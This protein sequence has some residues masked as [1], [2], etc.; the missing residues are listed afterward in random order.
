MERTRAREKTAGWNEWE[1]AT[2]WIW[3]DDKK[4]K[5]KLSPLYGK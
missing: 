1:M 5:L 2:D 3:Q 4:E